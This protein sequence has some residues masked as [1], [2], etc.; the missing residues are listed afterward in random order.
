VDLV[1]PAPAA[2]KLSR[3]TCREPANVPGSASCRVYGRGFARG[4]A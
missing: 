3:F 2:P 4:Y 1:V